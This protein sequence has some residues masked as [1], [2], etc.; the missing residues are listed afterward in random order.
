MKLLNHLA[1]YG[2][3]YFGKPTDI[4]PLALSSVSQHVTVLKEA[5]SI[6]GSDDNTRTCYCVNV[7]RLEEL[8][9]S[10]AALRLLLRNIFAIRRITSDLID[11][12]CGQ[13]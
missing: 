3:C 13:A 1:D 6:L 11:V 4:L 5:G 7:E 2:T 10:I 12:S 9:Q 8:Q